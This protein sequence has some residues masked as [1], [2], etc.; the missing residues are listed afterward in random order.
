MLAAGLGTA[1]A[2]PIVPAPAFN[3]ER[4][5]TLPPDEWSTNGGT[6]ANQR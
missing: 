5:S 2:Q 3:A 4:L 6:I 1:H